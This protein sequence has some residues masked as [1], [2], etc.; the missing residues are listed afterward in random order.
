MLTHTASILPLSASAVLALSCNA[1]ALEVIKLESSSKDMTPIVRKAIFDAQDPELKIVLA[2]GTYR[3][4][5]DYAFQKTCTITNHSNGLK[6]IIFPFQGLKSIEIE[7]NGAELVFHGQVLPFLFEDCQKV[8]ARG[9]SIDWDIPFI[10]Q[11]EVVA[12]NEKEGWRDIKPHTEGFGWELHRGKVLF[13]G[14]DGFNYEILGSTLAFDPETRRVSH[15]ALDM[16]SDPQRVEKRPGG[17]LR[18]H[19]QLRQYPAVG[20]VLTSKGD[21]AHDRYAP[22]VHVKESSNIHLEDVTVHHALGM[23]YLMERSQDI[24]M[25]GCSVVLK[26][27]TQRLISSTADATHFANCKGDILIENCRFENMLDDGTNVHGTYV[28]IDEVLDERSVRIKLE[29]FEQTGFRFAGEGD[30]VWFIKSPS[31]KRGRVNEVISSQPINDRFSILHFKDPLPPEITAGDILENKTWN[32]TFTMRGCT[33]RNHRARNIVLKSPLKTVI[34]DNDFSS[35]MSSVFFRGETFFWFESGSVNDVTIRNNRFN[36]CAYSGMEHAVLNITP[37]LGAAFD[38][39]EVYDSNIRFENN[40][41]HTFDSRIVWADRVDG[42][43][44]KD[45][46]IVR[47]D[48]AEPLYLDRA[49][50]DFKNCRNIEITGNSYDGEVSKDIQADDSSRKSLKV[51]GNTGF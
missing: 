14:V 20:S 26:D 17:I 31:P 29:H 37:R 32:P 21:R 22:A 39:E 5:P 40:T 12:V 48:D 27:D 44:I 34:E 45:N 2:P 38:Q 8:T 16:E 36:Y 1:S 51:E 10:F 13:P 11:G 30:E 24:V 33:I 43:V 9:F 47:T 41:I 3:F 28:T 7:G 18:F 23:G 15:G 4:L 19:E 46:T 25:S 6:N 42:L 49:L 35:M 50:F